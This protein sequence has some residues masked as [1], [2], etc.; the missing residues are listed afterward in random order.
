MEG[1]VGTTMIVLGA[2][3]IAVVVFEILE[4]TRR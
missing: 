1:W 3:L 4:R 2:A